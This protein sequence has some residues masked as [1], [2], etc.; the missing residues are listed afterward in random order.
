M[1][2]LEE[3]LHAKLLELEP[4]QRL[5]V[6]SWIELFDRDS[7]PFLRLR[8]ATPALVARALRQHTQND[9]HRR[10]LAEE[11]AAL[12]QAYTPFRVEDIPKNP[13]RAARL[14]GAEAYE[15]GF[16]PATLYQAMRVFLLGDGSFEDRV[17]TVHGWQSANSVE[18]AMTVIVRVG[19]GAALPAFP[20]RTIADLSADK[21]ALLQRAVK[22]WDEHGR[23]KATRVVE[24]EVSAVDQ[25]WAVKKA[26]DKYAA[27]AKTRCSR[28]TRGTAEADW[29]QVFVIDPAQK[30]SPQSYAFAPDPHRIAFP[31]R[32]SDGLSERLAEASKSDP[33][34]DPLWINYGDALD[35]VYG[36]APQRAL[37]YL[38]ATI[39]QAFDDCP[40]PEKMGTALFFVQVMSKLLALD[41]PSSY[42]AHLRTYLTAPSWSLPKGLLPDPRRSTVY[43]ALTRDS[44]WRP[45]RE[46][47]QWDELL[48]Y[49]RRRFLTILGSPQREVAYQRNRYSWDLVRAMGGRNR[50]VH[51][52]ERVDDE[53]LLTLLLFALDLVIRLRIASASRGEVFR[54]VVGD[55]EALF[56]RIAAGTETRPVGSWVAFGWN[57]WRG[58]LLGPAAPARS[59]AR[60]A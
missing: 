45:V 20:R 42:F 50:H 33:L 12:R 6:Q 35:L 41:W 29:S 59:G 24:I 58:A 52:A 34:L 56:D 4:Y 3:R 11:L 36:G 32:F 19:P 44:L 10:Y 27:S 57:G 8:P 43:K 30:P 13:V 38:A 48:A 16:H 5:F 23:S 49:H 15:L 54:E 31:G 37:N 7:P 28:T 53:H 60:S 46:K 55:A 21:K 17:E 22:W 47:T 18:R 2:R 1:R 26:K 14:L 25:G 9:Y 51:G 39:D 40:R